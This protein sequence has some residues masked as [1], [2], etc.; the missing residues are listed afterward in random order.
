MRPTKFLSYLFVFIVFFY[1]QSYAFTV[2]MLTNS[3]KFSSWRLT[4]VYL[5]PTVL[6]THNLLTAYVQGV[7]GDYHPRFCLIARCWQSS[8]L[9]SYSSPV[10]IV[11]FLL[12]FSISAACWDGAG[13]EETRESF[14]NVTGV[15]ECWWLPTCVVGQRRELWLLQIPSCM[16]T[17]FYVF[18]YCQIQTK[19]VAL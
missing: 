5:Q 19:L 3:V 4:V 15:G 2:A 16:Y 9:F 10:L 7:C 17:N 12:S 14:W 18:F 8:F 6:L 1:S 13:L 11:F